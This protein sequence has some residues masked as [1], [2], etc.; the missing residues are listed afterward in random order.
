[1][2]TETDLQ[3]IDR[4]LQA[5]ITSKGD[6]AYISIGGQLILMR[7]GKPFKRYTLTEV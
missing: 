1:M 3:V 6:L 5:S 2:E 4:L 7:E